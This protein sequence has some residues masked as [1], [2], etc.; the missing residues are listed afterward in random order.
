MYGQVWDFGIG[1]RLT[2]HD[3]SK[4]IKGKQPHHASTRLAVLLGIRQSTVGRAPGTTDDA[5]ATN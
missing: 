2:V 5:R 1:D 3:K 4:D